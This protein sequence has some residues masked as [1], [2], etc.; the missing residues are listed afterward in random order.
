MAPSPFYR[1]TFG[2]STAL[3]PSSLASQKEIDRF[4]T[5]PDV[6][7]GFFQVEEKT[8]KGRKMKVWS[9]MPWP[10]YRAYWIERSKTFA[11]LPCLTYTNGPQHT[12]TLTYSQAF[13]LSALLAHSL[14][15]RFGIK[16][17][18]RVGIAMRNTIEHTISW[19][20]VH[21]CGG[22]AVSLNAFAD[23]DT[24][25]FCTNDVGCSLVLTDAERVGALA[26]LVGQ[27]G[28]EGEPGLRDL[29]VVP[30]GRGKGRGRLSAKERAEYLSESRRVHDFDEVVKKAKDSVGGKQVPLPSVDLQPEDYAT[31]IF[32]SGT[33]GRPKG[34]LA[35]QR[36]SLHNLG[37]TLYVVPRCYLRR[38]RPLPDAEE[39]AQQPQVKTLIGYPLFHAA[40]LLSTMTTGM[41]KGEEMIS[42]YS[43]DVQEA[44]RLIGERGLTRVGATAHMVRQLATA[45]SDLPTLAA[46]THGGASPPSELSAELLAKTQ[47]GLTGT[48]YGATETNSMATG[49]YC[50]DYVNWPDSVG[51]APPTITI[52]IVDPE[53]KKE[54]KRGQLGEVWIHGAGIAEGYYRRPE[55]TREAF[56]PDGTYRTGD[57]GMM[58][59]DGALFIRDRIKDLII[60]GGENI[61]CTVV[62]KGIYAHPAISEAAAVALPDK[63]WGERIA[64]L[65]CV[66]PS[67]SSSSSSSSGALPSEEE[68]KAT[69]RRILTNR[70]EW[71]EFI[72]VQREPLERNPAGKVDKK[73]L[74]ARVLEIAKEKG[75]GD[76]AA[77]AAGAATGSTSNVQEGQRESKL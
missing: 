44:V 52:R 59:E 24:L 75:W 30:Y 23:E 7:G 48:G 33:T 11:S 15:T 5:S 25:R 21:L 22:V 54:V 67:S 34:V 1:S 3:P 28:K 55:A 20:S 56:L 73:M 35:T 2:P 27:E 16:K 46:V 45:A 40:G 4:L 62:E 9:G 70:Q 38:N 41:A 17:G 77:A 71:P 14:C 39:S 10:T 69:A 64:V 72:H 68:L 60:R 36:Q 43:W 19:W 50:D 74:R 53:T 49:C 63:K 65:C 47:G 51:W 57:V 6:A 76:Y 29:I 58:N 42:M 31:I 18:D 37:A 13:D 66:S 8:I 12:Y 61:S 26:S 32:T